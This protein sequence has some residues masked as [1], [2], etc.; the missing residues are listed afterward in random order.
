LKWALAGRVLVDLSDAGSG[1]IDFFDR[2]DDYDDDDDDTWGGNGPVSCCFLFSLK[3]KCDN[4]A[5]RH[6]FI[7][8]SR[9]NVS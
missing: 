1:L 8:N 5:I 7:R 2:Y 4:C 6:V 3:A 9:L